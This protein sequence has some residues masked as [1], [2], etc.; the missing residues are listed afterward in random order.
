[1]KM[2]EKRFSKKQSTSRKERQ[3]LIEAIRTFLSKKSNVVFAYIHGSFAEGEPFRDLDVA[4]YSKNYKEEI[5]LESDYSDELSKN[6]DYSVEAIVINQAPVAFQMSVLKKGILIVNKSEDI[7]TD[8]IE[9]VS[10]RYRQYSHFR[11]I[12]LKT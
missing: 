12:A 1:M 10:R 3:K 7:K 6:T 8:F 5:E 9:S 11:N 2:I 4:L